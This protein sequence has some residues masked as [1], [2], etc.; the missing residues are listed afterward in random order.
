MAKRL[1][2]P[3]QLRVR[4]LKARIGRLYTTRKKQL[5]SG[6]HPD[7]LPSMAYLIEIELVKPVYLV[8]ENSTFV[9]TVEA[10]AKAA[11]FVREWLTTSYDPTL[12]PAPVAKVEEVEPVKAAPPPQVDRPPTRVLTLDPSSDQ[13]LDSFYRHR[14]AQR[15]AQ[16]EARTRKYSGLTPNRDRGL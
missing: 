4:A 8:G 14:R 16:D 10:T 6:L 5:A 3:N 15:A 9:S 11:V 1:F 7:Q 13:L 2:T 12:A